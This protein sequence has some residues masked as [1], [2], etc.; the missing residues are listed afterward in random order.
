MFFLFLYIVIVVGWK[1]LR[2]RIFLDFPS[3]ADILIFLTIAGG[4]LMNAGI[5]LALFP[6]TLT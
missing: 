4:L 6:G 3:E 2:E 5:V 1:Q